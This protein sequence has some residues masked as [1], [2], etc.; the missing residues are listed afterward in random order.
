M[1]NGTVPEAQKIIVDLREHYNIFCSVVVY[2][3]VPKGIILIR[4]IPTAVHTLEDVSYTINAFK[5]IRQKLDSGE[6]AIE[7]EID[8]SKL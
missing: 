2:P 4:I 3:V 8:F 7:K 1:L 5:E 6:Y